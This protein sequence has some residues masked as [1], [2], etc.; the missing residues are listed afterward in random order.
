MKRVGGD[1]LDCFT[2]FL[3][4]FAGLLGVCNLCDDINKSTESIFYISALVSFNY[5]TCFYS[6]KP[7]SRNINE[8][9]WNK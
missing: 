7:L 5:W 2:V 1:I 9:S 6:F 3:S 4:V 8:N